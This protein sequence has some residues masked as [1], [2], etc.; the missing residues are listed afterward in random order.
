MRTCEHWSRTMRGV[1]LP[2]RMMISFFQREAL[3]QKLQAKCLVVGAKWDFWI[4]Q[5]ISVF[6]S[7]FFQEKFYPE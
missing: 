7:V 4:D 2:K 5:E 3:L 6:P 1:Q